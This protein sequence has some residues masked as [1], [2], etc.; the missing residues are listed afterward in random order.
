MNDLNQVNNALFEALSKA[1]GEIKPPLKNRTVD[2]TD[3]NGRRVF[4]KYADLADVMEALRIPFSKNGLA[5]THKLHFSEFENGMTTALIH[6]TGQR[7]T[8]FYPLPDPLSM[9]PQEFGSLL[10]FARRYSVSLIAGIA[11]EED[12][13]GQIAAQVPAVRPKTPP[14]KFDS[15]TEAKERLSEAQL[16]RLFAISNEKEWTHDQVKFY[17]S[18]RWELESTKDLTPG[19]YD[20][21][22]NT[23]QVMS[24][25]QAI[26]QF[27]DKV[28]G[29]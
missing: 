16:K 14:R 20:M 22:V 27:H 4:Y 19:Q 25:V 21:L 11:S 23:I 10:T 17:M 29:D 5:I 26:K 1:Q 12:D 9:R 15:P 3:K 24:Y 28:R 6:S 8:T 2:F 18:A 7:E 13:D